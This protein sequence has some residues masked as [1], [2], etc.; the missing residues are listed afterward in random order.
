M[1]FYIIYSV[2]IQTSSLCSFVLQYLLSTQFQYVGA[3]LHELDPVFKNF[4]CSDEIASLLFSLGHQRPVIMQSMYI[5]KVF[6]DLM[7]WYVTRLRVS[8]FT[9]DMTQFLL[10]YYIHSIQIDYSSLTMVREQNALR[11]YIIFINYQFA[12]KLLLCSSNQV[13]VEK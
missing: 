1:L 7:T 9:I 3:A 6:Q 11:I 4:C 2:L 10:K 13:S 5:F 12:L 8:K